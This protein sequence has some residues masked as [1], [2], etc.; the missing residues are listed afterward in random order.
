MQLKEKL[1]EITSLQISQGAP[2]EAGGGRSLGIALA[3]Q[4]RAPAR[5]TET[6]RPR[7]SDTCISSR[8]RP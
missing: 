7:G 5:E 2:P 3:P 6:L 1:P 4:G 8:P